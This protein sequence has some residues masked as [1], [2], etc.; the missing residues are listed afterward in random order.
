MTKSLFNKLP[1]EI[2]RKIYAYI[3]DDAINEIKTMTYL[4]TSIYSIAHHDD[5]ILNRHIKVDL[6]YGDNFLR[7]KKEKQLIPFEKD[8]KI[9]RLEIKLNKLRD[10]YLYMA[11]YSWACNGLYLSKH[12][13]NTEAIKEDGLTVEEIYEDFTLYCDKMIKNEVIEKYTV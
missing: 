9:K 11:K 2:A 10:G 4:N 13:L 12:K 6:Y 5:A 1:D 7:M 3:Y 8:N